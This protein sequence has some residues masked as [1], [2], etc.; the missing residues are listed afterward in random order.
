[1]CVIGRVKGCDISLY[2]F[3]C[4]NISYAKVLACVR[5]GVSMCYNALK[6]VSQAVPQGVSEGV[7]FPSICSD[8]IMQPVRLVLEDVIERVRMC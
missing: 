8:V 2:L 6:G 4:H 5:G 3:G 1:M 7:L